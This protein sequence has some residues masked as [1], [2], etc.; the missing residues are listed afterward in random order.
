MKKRIIYLIANLSFV[1]S[2][3]FLIDEADNLDYVVTYGT[4]LLLLIM[5]NLIATTIIDIRD[6][7][8]GGKND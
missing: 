1:Q 2:Y 3:Y 8:W 5:A 7:I 6:L 4:C